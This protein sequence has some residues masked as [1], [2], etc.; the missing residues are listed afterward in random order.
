MHNKLA[1]VWTTLKH[2]PLAYYYVNENSKIGDIVEIQISKKKS[3]GVIFSF[4]NETNL[5]F[6]TKTALATAYKFS[7]EYIEF[8]LNFEKF[9]LNKVN[10]ILKTI[11]NLFKK[12]DPASKDIKSI[13]LAHIQFNLND[14]QTI[15]CETIN[16]NNH[17]IYLLW[18]VTGSGKTEVFFQ[19][20]LECI[21][22]QKQVLLLLPEIVI[23]ESILL[24]FESKFGFSPSLWHS[25]SKNKTTF[26]NVY[27][28]ESLIIIGSR[29]A[30]FLPFKNLGLI[31]IDEEHD[32]SYKQTNFPIYNCRDMCV[33]LS[34]IYKINLILASATPSLET[35]YNVNNNKYKL[36]TLKKRFF[37]TSLPKMTFQTTNEIFSPYCLERTEEELNKGNQ[38]IYFLNKRGFA[39]IVM[40]KGCFHRFVCKK[41]ESNVTFHKQK[42]VLICHK[43]TKQYP[44]TN[45]NVC[46][47]ANTLVSYG[48]G[49]EKVTEL[50][51]LKF[52]QANIVTVS[53]DTC[54]SKD[55]IQNII[56]NM[57]NKNIN[58]LVG[59][60]I[61]S[62][63]HD[64]P[65]ISLVVAINIE[66]NAFDFRCKETL[67]QNL[68]QLSGRAGRANENS[69]IIVQ[70][71][72]VQ[73]YSM[74]FGHL[75]NSDYLNFSREELLSRE[76][77]EL[78]P[79]FKIIVIKTSH[80][81]AKI[82]YKNI[83]YLQNKLIYLSN[84]VIKGPILIHNFTDIKIT[85]YNLILKLKRTYFL[86]NLKKIS[87]ILEN[88]NSK[89]SFFI[90][91]D[92]YDLM[93]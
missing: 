5:S 63:G 14:E 77:Y 69:E 76:K 28:G 40:C 16:N 47:A 35:L 86:E 49:V 48:F 46:E 25:K 93:I 91:V 50:L 44:L 39:N 17:S 24:R 64:F 18:G 80:K 12:K 27:N 3:L 73:D 13:E 23:T 79:F 54:D 71:N 41:C 21:K 43:C 37:A 61:L 9:T 67:F 51:L 83:K 34:K 85:Q 59:T 31:I 4:S 19:K 7:W 10:S 22:A 88:L 75:K 74:F 84:T 68:V 20:I 11:L 92:S 30:M 53:S 8:L 66:Q 87:S 38:I 70:T 81:N 55:K 78:P 56:S 62:K 32:K 90:D 33:I 2:F 52:P 42:E 1:K 36:L 45:C 29:S 72:K 58:I 65:S 82:A 26:M 6:K 15:A 60:Q 57:K 89:M